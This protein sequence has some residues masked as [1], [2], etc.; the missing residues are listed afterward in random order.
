MVL[1]TKLGAIRFDQDIRSVV[2]YMSS[3]TAFGDAR[4]KFQRLQQISTILNLDRVS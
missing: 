1:G 2:A 3:Q 4:E